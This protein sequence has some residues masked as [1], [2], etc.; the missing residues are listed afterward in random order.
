MKKVNYKG[1]QN[2]IR[3][4]LLVIASV[5]LCS[6]SSMYNYTDSSSPSGFHIKEN[7]YSSY[8][9]SLTGL[10][11]MLGY[12]TFVYDWKD[13]CKILRSC[14]VSKEDR[15]MQEHVLRNRPISLKNC[16]KVP[17]FDTSIY[18]PSVV[19]D[20]THIY[21]K[22]RKKRKWDIFEYIYY[23]KSGQVSYIN[24]WRMHP[25][26]Q[27]FQN[28]SEELGYQ[29][30]NYILFNAC[31]QNLNYNFVQEN[32]LQN[33]NRLPV[34]KD[35]ASNNFIWRYVRMM[36]H[37]TNDKS[38]FPPYKVIY[39]D[40]KST[41]YGDTSWVNS[42]LNNL[43]EYVLRKVHYSA[44]DS[45]LL[46]DSTG[47]IVL[48]RNIAADVDDFWSV[49]VTTPWPVLGNSYSLVQ[50][51][52]ENTTMDKAKRLCIMEYIVETESGQFSLIR[53]WQKKKERNNGNSEYDPFNV[54]DYSRMWP[55]MGS[56]L[57]LVRYNAQNN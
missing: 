1:L 25:K 5:L 8:S 33:S 23:T 39:K 47:C 53:Y 43:Q 55:E 38:E 16:Y 28:R 48:K 13:Y 2:T 17:A 15:I 19:T 49:P 31:M 26:R 54:Y 42:P 37:H 57:Y 27:C 7:F 46:S 44:N 45:V 6:C 11:L 21:V 10:E 9:D 12:T 24:P 41:I 3:Y 30:P 34:L 22:H 52:Y 4:I 40:E 29:H 50:K 35:G 36:G 20:T 32:I 14:K 51:Y 18:E 56:F